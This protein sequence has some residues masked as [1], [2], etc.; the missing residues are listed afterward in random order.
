MT[1]RTERNRLIEENLPLVGFLAA[2][3][4][5]RA[6]HLPHEDLAAVGALALVQA[7]DAYDPTLGVPFGA[8]ARRRILGAF[9]D[10]MRSMDW[11]SR[12]I[13]KRIKEVTAVRDTLT[14]GLGRTPTVTEIATTMGMSEEAVAEGLA[15]AARTVTTLDDP[16]AQ[17]V[18]SVTELPEETA[19]AAE[20]RR[21][22]TAAVEALPS[23]MRV[24][25]QAVYVDERP[26][27]DVAAQLG[28][29]HSAVSQQRS[30]AIRLLRDALETFFGERAGAQVNSRAS[31]AVR[32]AFLERVAASLGRSYTPPLADARP[33]RGT[34]VLITG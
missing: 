2:D 28:V 10:E 19:E 7:A 32:T 8:Y 21:V 30:E 3:L 16:F 26:V 22:L 25:V 27:K 1:S 31:T 33:D 29:S 34:E 23:R 6:S 9:A 24:I 14:A 12:G 11:A 18:V 13:R 5:A 20:R 17:E 15:D 4:H